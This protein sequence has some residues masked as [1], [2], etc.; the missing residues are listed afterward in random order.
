MESNKYECRIC[1]QEA[2]EPVVTSCGHMFC[3]SC[4]DKWLNRNLPQLLCPVCKAGISK[5]TLIPLY[6]NEETKDPRSETPRPQAHR[7]EPKENPKYS[8][9][10]GLGGMN[11]G[12][13]PSFSGV[14]NSINTMNH[15]DQRADFM[16][17]LML[18]IGLVIL[19]SVLI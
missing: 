19:M 15:N 16:S 8:R 4:I 9:L 10:G 13:A 11:L 5:E 18:L 7:E 12:V 3:W 1:I 2:V 14:I 6:L 17:K